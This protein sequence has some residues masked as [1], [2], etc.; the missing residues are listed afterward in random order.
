VTAISPT[1]GSAGGGDPVTVT[2]TGFTGATS[3]TFGAVVAT[4]V[5]FV[6]D[7]TLLVTSPLGTDGTTVHVT[8]TTTAGTS[9]TTADDQ[10]TY[11]V[12]AAALTV[13][14]VN[15]KTGKVAGGDPVKVTGTGF[16]GA[17]AVTFGDAAATNLKF[18][19]DT[20]LTVTSPPGTAGTV[21][22]TVTTTAGTSATTVNDQF[23]YQS[24]GS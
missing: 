14:E 19:S 22:V 1:S 6:S 4:N 5:K 9:A 12:R 10:F 16:T 11:A 3:V 21:H 24:P 23:T 13:T 8:V 7:T 15:P 17:T 18:V 2:G 20:T